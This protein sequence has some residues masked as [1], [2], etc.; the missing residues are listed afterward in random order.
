LY[1]LGGKQGNMRG[2]HIEMLRTAEHPS[3]LLSHPAVQ[4][5]CMAAPSN[6]RADREVVAAQ[7]LLQLPANRR[8]MIL[9]W[10]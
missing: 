6:P 8:V 9:T 1:A 3:L 10:L 4:P 2:I 5:E 7:L